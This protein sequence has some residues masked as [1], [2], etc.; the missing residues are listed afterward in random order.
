VCAELIGFFYSNVSKALLL[1]NSITLTSLRTPSPDFTS[2]TFITTAAEPWFKVKVQLIQQYFHAFVVNLASQVNDIIFVD[3]HAGN[4]AYS[5]GH[6]KGKFPATSL[7]AMATDL[8][9]SRWILCERD[10]ENAKVLKIRINRHFKNKNVLLFT[11]PLADLPG[12]MAHYIPPSKGG[13]KAAVVCVADGFSLDL[14]FSLMERFIHLGFSFILPFTFCINEHHNYEFYAREQG[15]KLARF[16]GTPEVSALK[17]SLSNL[18]FYKRLVKMYQNSMLMHGLH[19]T[20][21][22]HKLDSGLMELPLYYMGLFSK[23]VA[24]RHIRNEVL[25]RQHHQTSLF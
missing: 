17:G 10:A 7:A 19:G 11:D 5:L 22:V 25:A 8:P 12:K 6:Q 18:E 23:Y 21:T 16:V 2:D 13:Y 15:D 14:P 3:L 1:L 20:L 4:G 9:I 24:A